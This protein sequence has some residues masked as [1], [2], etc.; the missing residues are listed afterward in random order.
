MGVQPPT[1]QAFNTS[2]RLPDYA[3]ASFVLGGKHVRTTTWYAW[4][5]SVSRSRQL[6]EN[7]PTATFGTN[8]ATS[9]CQYDPAANPSI[10]RPQWSQPCYTEAHNPSNFL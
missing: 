7:D 1:R 6:G 8:L 5:V 9:N 3:I 4:D 2:I 10:Y